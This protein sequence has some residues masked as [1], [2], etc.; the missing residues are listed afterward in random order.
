[1]KKL[2]LDNL[3]VESFDTTTV[4]GELQGTVA[5]HEL[6]DTLRNCPVSYGGTCLIS[7]CRTC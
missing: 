6:N 4:A 7:A 1:M 5:A 3:K 2:Q